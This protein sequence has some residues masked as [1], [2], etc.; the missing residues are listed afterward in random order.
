[1]SIHCRAVILLMS[2]VVGLAYAGVS[3]PQIQAR[4]DTI[5]FGVAIEG[6]PVHAVF[7]ISNVGDEPLEISRVWASCGCTAAGLTERVIEP[8]YARRMEV[9]F[10]TQGYGGRTVTTHVYIESNDP[11]T[12]RFTLSLVGKV[13][14]EAAYLIDVEDLSRELKLLIDVREREA[15]ALGHLLGAVSLT[16]EDADIWFEILPTDVRIVLYDQGGESADGLAEQMIKLGFSQVYVMI[17]GLDEWTRRYG[18]RMIT[19]LPLLVGVM[20]LDNE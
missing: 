2:A 4:M 11:A 12:P 3:A 9:T 15:Y 20:T 10:N 5:N 1:M 13:V 17:G 14:P 16:A 19:T 18:D 7:E 8:G 6:E